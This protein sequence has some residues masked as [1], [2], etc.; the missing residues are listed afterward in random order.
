[1]I[2]KFRAYGHPNILAIHKTTLEFTKDKEVTLK[3]DCIVGVNSDFQL[4]RVKEFI[5]SLKNNKIKITIKA[6]GTENQETMEAEINHSFNSDNEV[7]IRK[8]G[9][10]SGRT[11]AVNASKASFEL[12]RS[13]IS[14]LKK[15]GSKVMVIFGSLG[16]E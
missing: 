14:H 7:V 10:L 1:M 2:Y 9:F 16:K 8:T 12:N 5:R 6:Q 3:G 4:S 15:D 13:L 11:F